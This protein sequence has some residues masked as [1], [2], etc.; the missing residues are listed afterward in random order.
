MVKDDVSIIGREFNGITRGPYGSIPGI[1]NSKRDPEQ[2]GCFIDK[3]GVIQG[4][5]NLGYL[6]SYGIAPYCVIHVDNPE[7]IIQ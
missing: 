7:E 3:N 5:V 6:Q 1:K 4:F 2:A